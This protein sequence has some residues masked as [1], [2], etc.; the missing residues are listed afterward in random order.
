MKEKIKKYIKE[1][2]VFI[3]LFFILSTAVSLYRTNSMQIGDGVCRDGVQVVYFW[4]TWCPVCKVTSP[5]I[6]R[7]SKEFDVLGISVR[8]GS[9]EEVESYMQKR[10]LHYRNQ[11][12]QEGRMAEQ[13]GI[14]VFPTVVF[15]KDGDVKM[16]EAGYMSTFGLWLRTWFLSL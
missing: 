3:V 13:Y 8:S 2:L 10:K 9:E 1:A 5:N 4:A 6:E 12:D 14:N 11:N 7:I 16:A 15:C